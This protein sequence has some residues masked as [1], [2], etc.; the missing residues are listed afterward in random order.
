MPNHASRPNRLLMVM[1]NTAILTLGVAVMVA[2]AILG[3]AHQGLFSRPKGAVILVPLG[4]SILWSLV[5][6]L[7]CWRTR[8]M[9]E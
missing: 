3:L 2:I 8:N 6:A 5:C 1:T 7:S 4:V 9:V